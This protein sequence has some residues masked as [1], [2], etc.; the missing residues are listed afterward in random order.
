MSKTVGG[1]LST[2][3]AGETTTLATMF[4]LTRQDGTVLTMTTHDK[5][6]D[7]PVGSPSYTYSPMNSFDATSVETSSGMNVDNLDALILL[8]S[9]LLTEA[10]LKAGL[11]RYAA[12][13]IFIVN[14]ADLSM[15]DVI[16]RAGTIGETTVNRSSGTFNAELR[17]RMQPLQQTIGRVYSALC[18]ARLGDTRCGFNLASVTQSGVVT[19]AASRRSFSVNGISDDIFNGGLV[20]WTSGLNDGLT[21]EVKLWTGSPSDTVEL[22]DAMPFNIVAGDTFTMSPGC[23]RNL[24]TCRDTYSNVANFRGFPF[25]PGR[26]AVLRYPDSPV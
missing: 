12:I 16:L 17:G 13:E 23:D 9:D 18:D 19:V 4:K 10:D 15:G 14:W 25:I 8:D 26:D 5:P 11:Y 6:L 2:H 22:F 3:M 21:M 1:S 20:T 7:Y 24:S